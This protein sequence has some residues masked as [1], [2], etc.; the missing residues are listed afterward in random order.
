MAEVNSHRQIL[1]A[2]SI[3]GSASA[4]NILTGIIRVKVLAVLLG[5]AGVGL[6]GLY[7]T[8]MSTASGL[9]AFGLGSSGVRQI[10]AAVGTGDE[11]ELSV[12]RNT[13]WR[14]SLVLGVVGMGLI[15]ILRGQISQWV[16]GDSTHA[17]AVGWLG[18]GVLLGPLGAAQGALLQ[19][20]RR[21]SDLAKISVISSAIGSVGAIACVYALG[22][23]G[24]LYFVLLN[25]VVGV[26]V[27]WRYAA[28]LPRPEYSTDFRAMRSQTRALVG[29]GLALMAAGLMQNLTSLLVRGWV[30]RDLGIEA[31]GQ[32][33]AAWGI[34]MQYIGFV[35]GAMGA[36]YYPRLTATI[37][38]RHKANRLVN[39]QTEMALLMAGPVLLAMLSFTPLVVEL[40][41]TASFGPAVDILR[42]QVLGDLVK[43]FAWPPGFILLALGAGR[44]YFLTELT[45]NL[46]YLACVRLAMPWFGLQAT[47][48]GFLLSYI[49]L[50]GVVYLVACRL[51]GFRWTSG[52]LRLFWALAVAGGAIHALSTVSDSLTYAVGLVLTGSMALYSTWRLNQLMNIRE[53][54]H[55]KLKRARNQAEKD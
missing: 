17:F 12:V 42:W 10:A 25:P 16:F 34:S 30:A 47:G 27:A 8:I 9:A 33:Q 55:L 2:T 53:W 36:D 31:T 46:C 14:L 50:L 21:I 22:Q 23:D 39:E 44:I 29:L 38:D 40:F 11:R 5:P 35:L 54:L 26:L 37:Q 28:R 49:V 48:V 41:Y 1:R 51:T 6:A 7:S 18:I 13:L 4:V 43:V 15:W 19:G 24:V 20:F 3:V 52:N 45:W 32:F